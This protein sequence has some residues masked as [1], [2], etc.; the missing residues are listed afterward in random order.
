LSCSP[1]VIGGGDT[2]IRCKE[3]WHASKRKIYTWFWLKSL[4]EGYHLENLDIDGDDH[5]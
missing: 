3:Q 1:N 4:M 5:V 2:R